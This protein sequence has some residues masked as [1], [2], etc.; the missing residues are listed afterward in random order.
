[1]PTDAI[2]GAG[3]FGDVWFSFLRISDCQ[4]VRGDKRSEAGNRVLIAVKPLLTP[5]DNFSELS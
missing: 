1:M 5:G 2:K 4:S 3:C